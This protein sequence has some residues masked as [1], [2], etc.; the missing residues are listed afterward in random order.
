[1]NAALRPLGYGVLAA[2]VLAGGWAVGAGVGPLDVGRAEEI[3]HDAGPG[4]NAPVETTDPGH[5]DTGGHSDSDDTNTDHSDT[6]HSESGGHSDTGH[7]TTSSAEPVGLAQA[8]DGYRLDLVGQ[9]RD[10]R[11]RFR[12]LGPTHD[13]TDS[14]DDTNTPNTE[15]PVT[16]YEEVHDRNLH[17]IVVR[18]DLGDYQHLHPRLGPDGTWSVAAR[19]RP[20]STRVLAD[21]TPTGGEPLVLGTDVSLPGRVDP[22]PTAPATRRDD[23]ADYRVTLDGDLAAGQPGTLTARV[24]RAGVP[25]RDLQPYLG[26]YGHLVALREGDLAYLHVHPEDGGPGPGIGFGT[27]IP[28]PGR[29]RLFLDFKHDDTVRTAAFTLDVGAQESRQ[30]SPEQSPEQYGEEA[31]DGHSH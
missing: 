22:V 11:L 8:Q 30:Q 3:A 15:A 23:V 12:I 25:V 4:H 19:L 1:M 13:D 2:A 14:H 27:T 20:G 31:G 16:S 10:G 21:F 7:T 26:A 6:G 9:P 17:L 29:Y 28:T 18:R 5:S 24:E